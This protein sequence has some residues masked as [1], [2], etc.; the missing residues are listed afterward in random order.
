MNVYGWRAFDVRSAHYHSEQRHCVT[1]TTRWYLPD[2]PRWAK[3][4]VPA[5]GIILQ[6]AG[7]L[8]GRHEHTYSGEQFAPLAIKLESIDFPSVH[9]TRSESRASRSEHQSSISSSPHLAWGRA[10]V[11]PA[12]S[13][14]AGGDANDELRRKRE[15][16][17]P[18]TL[19][20]QP[21]QSSTDYSNRSSPPISYTFTSPDLTAPI[22]SS[23]RI[24]RHRRQLQEEAEAN[25]AEVGTN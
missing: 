8:L 13:R 16:S 24:R 23:K 15:A 4:R 20:E 19:D 3:T 22:R 18:P 1:F 11:P 7:K 9:Q 5:V 21:L 6:L 2:G 25:N 12:L 14:I 10:R 17:S